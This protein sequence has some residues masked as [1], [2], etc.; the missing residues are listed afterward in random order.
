MEFR[1][2]PDK[3][4]SLL[5]TEEEITKLEKHAGNQQYMDHA[6]TFV[7]D[8]NAMSGAVLGCSLSKMFEKIPWCNDVQVILPAYNDNIYLINMKPEVV[9]VLIEKGEY[10]ARYTPQSEATLEIRRK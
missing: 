3:D 1:V 7:K 9:K 4:L 8:A 2:S 5:L 6:I 10:K